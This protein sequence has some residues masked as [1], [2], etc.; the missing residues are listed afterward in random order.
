MKNIKLSNL[1]KAISNY[2][3]CSG[4]KSEQAKKKT[5]ICHTVPKTFDFSQN[6]CVPFHQVTFYHSISYVQKLHKT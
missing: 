4:I 1:I 5:A 3:I 2:N 6:S